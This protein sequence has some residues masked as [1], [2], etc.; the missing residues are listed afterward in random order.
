MLLISRYAF[1]PGQLTLFDT[2]TQTSSTIRYV[3]AEHRGGQTPSSAHSSLPA[4]TNTATRDSRSPNKVPC[5]YF[6]SATALPE[7]TTS[8]QSRSTSHV[9]VGPPDHSD[10]SKMSGQLWTEN[11]LV[12][13]LSASW[14]SGE[15]L[16]LERSD[17]ASAKKYGH[18]YTN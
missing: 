9:S 16:V 7:P 14:N 18:P 1:G 15:Q 8:P 12:Q 13:R 11:P 10:C 4:S 2:T 6:K 17:E 3:Q 5:F